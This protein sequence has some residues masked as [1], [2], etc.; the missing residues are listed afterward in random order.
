[1]SSW[2]NL[3][4]IQRNQVMFYQEVNSTGPSI[5]N[6]GDYPGGPILYGATILS[7]TKYLNNDE[8]FIYFLVT[9]LGQQI[10]NNSD[11]DPI[12]VPFIYGQAPPL[13]SQLGQPIPAYIPTN[14]YEEI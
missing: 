2:I 10:L 8:A 14:S 12:S 9:P 4:S 5:D 3:G 7:K 13:I 1:M 6:I 11:F